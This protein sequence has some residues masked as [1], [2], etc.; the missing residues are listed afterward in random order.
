M[1]S[2]KTNSISKTSIF[3]NIA[4]I[5]ILF[6]STSVFNNAFSQVASASWALTADASVTGLSGNISATPHAVNAGLIS[7]GTGYEATYGARWENFGGSN[8]VP[9]YNAYYE[10]TVTPS[11]C[12]SLEVTSISFTYRLSFTPRCYQ[13]YYSVAGGAD[14]KIGSDISPASANVSYNYNSGA[15]SIPVGVGETIRFRL[16]GAGSAATDFGCRDFVVNG[17]TTLVP[18]TPSVSIA[19][20]PLGSICPATSVTFTATPTLGG[21]TPSYQWKLNGSN[22]GS[23]SPTYINA[24]LSNADQVS[25]V[26]T[27]NSPCASPTTATS[28]TISMSVV[29]TPAQPGAISGSVNVAESTGGLVYNIAAVPDADSYTWT[30]PTGWTLNSGQSTTSITVTSGA[31][32][33]DGDITV[34]ATN[35]CGTS[36]A[37]VLAVAVE[38]PHNNCNQ[39]HIFHDAP[40]VTL[41]NVGG[42]ANL[43]ISCHNPAGNASSK[44]FAN[45]DK[46]VPSVSGTSHSWDIPSVNATYETNLTTIPDMLTRVVNDT[47]VCSTCHD[48]HTSAGIGFLRTSNNGDAMCKDC[49]SPRNVGI[50]TNDNTNNKG[51]HP[52]GLAYNGADSRFNAAPTSM[53]IVNGKIECLSCHQMH[54]ANTNDGTLLRANNDANFCTDCHAYKSHKSM[55]CAVC[56][57]TH[58]NNKANIYMIR[59]SI[60]TPN[61]GNRTVSFIAETGTN[62]FADGNGSYDGIC[63]V[64]HTTP[65]HHTN[66]DD[67]GTHQDAT[68][69]TT[70]HP[71]NSRFF[72]QTQCLSCHNSA[73]GS[74]RIITGASGDFVRTSHHAD[75]VKAKDC[76]ICHYMGNHMNG[77]VQLMDPDL[78]DLLVYDYDS[79]NKSTVENFCI[80]CH[81]ADGVNGDLTPFTDNIIV[82]LVDNTKWASSSHKNS[83]Y[84]CMDC[85]DNGHG[86]NKDKMLEPY[87]YAGDASADPM[88]DEEEFCENCHKSSGVASTDIESEFNRTHTHQV[89]EVN[90]SSTN[91]GL[92][93]INCHNPHYNTAT[94][95]TSNPDNTDNN[96]TQIIDGDRD[97]CLK[98]HD[99]SPP[100][101]I[102][103]PATS[104]GTGWDKSNYVGSRHDQVINS[105][106]TNY[107]GVVEDCSFCHEHHGAN[108]TANNTFTGIYT[109][110]KGKYDKSG[111]SGSF[112]CNNWDNT[113]E[114]DYQLCWDCHN[115]DLISSDNGGFDEHRKHVDGEGAPCI[116]CH[117][118]HN[119]YDAGEPSLIN[120]EYSSSP[121]MGVDVDPNGNSLSN[122]FVGS[123]CNLRCH[124]APSGCG[125]MNHNSENYGG[126]YLG[127]PWGYTW[128]K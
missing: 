49:H 121:V 108:G 23:D 111:S 89:N 29:S 97:F 119:A 38:L 24:S 127:Y 6:L 47:I 17:T 52:V 92:E 45:A 55:D 27:S 85:H 76:V 75:N 81:D 80:N 26:M 84:T 117:D 113:E 15:L 7:I 72:P 61:S 125:S 1:E 31:S 12:Y 10:F 105:G 115:R 41:T 120:F 101:G 70:C 33:Q 73:Q 59:N 123:V 128:P 66:T 62:S 2:Y 25:C 102:T 9:T 60:T 40:G 48:Q 56:H 79:G 69:C 51:S 42:N 54:F 4:I 37:S 63:E 87:A 50:Y 82:P 21:S 5:A 112:S 3:I 118:V 64:C 99:G 32:G 19:A 22:V 18:S 28:N 106:E 88:N 90:Q 58:N 114:G 122:M 95:P 78:R 36:A 103:F 30:V 77:T 8:C 126:T 13:L 57:Q 68:N 96:W 109:M 91:S 16:Y 74:R 11:N 107:V 100:A 94:Y 35:T 43:C 83:T 93:C 34:T 14:T 20:N 124:E 67:G 98:C 39:C 71:H 104:Y 65:I 116:L 86:S 46:A 110:L 53:Q 44:P